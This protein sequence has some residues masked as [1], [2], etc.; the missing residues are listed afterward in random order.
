MVHL[1]ALSRYYIWVL[2]VSSFR[3]CI[4]MH[5]LNESSECNYVRLLFYFFNLHLHPG[6]LVNEMTKIYF[7]NFF[8]GKIAFLRF[9]GKP[10]FD[11]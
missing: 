4:Q 1:D 6:G 5:N 9:G 7:F 3:L 8:F 10:F 2:F 11:F